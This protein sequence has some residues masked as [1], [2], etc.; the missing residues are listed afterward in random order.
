MNRDTILLKYLEL[1][2]IVKVKRINTTRVSGVKDINLEELNQ[3][4]KFVQYKHFY[5]NTRALNI[6]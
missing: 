5:L 4:G 1:P 2:S 3:V 6:C